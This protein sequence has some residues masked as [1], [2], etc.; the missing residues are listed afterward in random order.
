[1]GD[2]APLDEREMQREMMREAKEEFELLGNDPEDFTMT[3]RR[4]AH[5]RSAFIVVC[6]LES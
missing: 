2:D 4:A 3:V 6:G 5:C 1:M